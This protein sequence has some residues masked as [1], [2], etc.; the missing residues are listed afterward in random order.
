M[1]AFRGGRGSRHLYI[2][3]FSV[4]GA[5]AS[6]S[7]Q[8]LMIAHVPEARARSSA[9][10]NP[11]GLAYRFAVD[12]QH[13]GELLEIDFAEIVA[14]VAALFPVLLNLSAANL[15]HVHVVADDRDVRKAESNR[16]L[17]IEAGHRKRAVAEQR[18]D[19]TLGLRQLGGHRESG[20]DA[21]RSE[22]TGI[23]PESR[24]FW[25]HDVAGEGNDVAAVA[26]E[27]R[28]V[29]EKLVDFVR[30]AI[31]MNRI[32]IAASVSE[33]ALQP[34]RF[35]WRASISPIRCGPRLRSSC[36]PRRLALRR[37]RSRRRRRPARD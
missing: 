2:V 11:S 27:D 1:P 8:T 13:V 30:E 32:G 37:L 34:R 7:S 15:I 12:A 29:G 14:D 17:D 23:H 6:G 24:T 36:D 4:P 21:E 31:R 10:T 5:Y 18:D 3:W 35:P 20:A 16:G 25:T 19:F 9:G 26:D 33:G 22:R 28:V